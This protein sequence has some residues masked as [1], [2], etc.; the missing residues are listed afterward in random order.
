MKVFDRFL[1]A[2]M[3]IA[4]VSGV[5]AQAFDGGIG[6]R[7]TGGAVIQTA[8]VGGAGAEL[9]VGVVGDIP[10]ADFI[11]LRLMVDYVAGLQM[12]TI[13][14]YFF[15]GFLNFYLSKEI[16]LGIGAG[17]QLQMISFMGMS[18]SAGAPYGALEF[19]YVVPLSTNLGL[20]LGL[21]ATMPMFSSG[22]VFFDVRACVGL[23]FKIK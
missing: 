14:N 13:N 11:G 21:I 16:Y 18:A 5:S 20:D 22:V 4:A 8:P 19:G 3:V 17:Y 15:G 12:L 10:F 7:V 1:I 2:V 6:V 23:Q 9:G